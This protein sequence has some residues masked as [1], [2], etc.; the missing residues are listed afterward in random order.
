MSQIASR[1]SGAA[2][3]AFKAAC[4]A[5]LALAVVTCTDNPIGPARPGLARLRVAP[6]F[7]AFARVAPLAMDRFTITVVRPPADTLAR[8]TK[9]FSPDSSAVSVPIDIFLQSTSE[10]VDVTIELYAGS[11]LLF[12]GTQS[13]TVTQGGSTPP[14]SI[15]VAYQGP[16]SQLASLVIGPR[17]TTV[18]FG[19]TFAFGATAQDSQAAPVAQ[20][21]VAW[22]ASGGTI[23]GAGEFTAPAA[24]DTV[25]VRAVTPTGVTDSTTVIIAAAPATLVKV[26]GDA[27]SGIIGSRLALPLG[28]RVDGNDGLPV[29]GVPVT[30]AVA[31]GGGSVDSA[32]VVTDGA[33]LA[34]MGATLG[35]TVGA[36]SFTASAPGLTAVTFA[37]TGT[38]GG[39]KTWT[40][41]VSTAWTTAGNW[42]PAAVP[43]TG[44]SVLVP[45]GAPNAPT[46]S[47][48]IA[49]GALELSGN[50]ATLTIAGTFT[51]AQG[52]VLPDTSQFIQLT[53]GSLVAGSLTLDG[54]QAFVDAS[55]GGLI[56]SG[57]T[58]LAGTSA[59]VDATGP[60]SNSLG[61]VILSGTSA[62]LQQNG[63]SSGPL[64]LNGS[65]AFWNPSGAVTVNGNPAAQVT[66]TS[67]LSGGTSGAKVTL[68][69]DVI[70]GGTAAFFSPNT[71]DK[72][73]INGDLSTTGGGTLV[74]NNV[75]DTIEVNGNVSFGGGDESASLVAGI[76]NVSGNF[77]QTGPGTT[78]IGSGAHTVFLDGTGAQTLTFAAPGFGAGRFQNVI[79]ANS[80]G[81]V[82][83]TSDLYA[84]GTAGV[85]PTA[86]RTL[87]GNGST[88]FTTILSVSNFTFNNLLLDF[89]G[90][91]VV[92]FDTVSF[93]GYAPTATPLTIT[94]PGAASALAFQDVSFSV[95]PTSGFYLDATDSNPS[96]GVPLV[97]DMLNPNPLSDGGRVLE[98]GGA[99]VNWPAGVAPGTW[100]GVVDTSWNTAG[101]WSDGQVPTATTDVT[102]PSGTPFSPATSGAVR[103]VR[104]L[105]VQAGATLTMGGGGVN[106]NGSL[107]AAGL[108]TGNVAGMSLGGTGT[109]RGNVTGT[110]FLLTV[111][112]TYTL[113]GRLVATSVTV[114]GS[115]DL[116]GHTAAVGGSGA[117][118]NFNTANNGVLVMQSPLD[119][120]IMVS[121]NP[122]VGFD[123][124]STAGLLTDGVIVMA[125]AGFSTF[126]QDNTFNAASYAPSGNH[127]VVLATGTTLSLDFATPGT[128]SHFNILDV[129]AQ[130]PG[131]SLSTPIRV[132]GLFISTPASTAPAINGGNRLLTLA[133]G[134]QVTGLTLTNAPVA[135]T[136]DSP[137]TFDNVALQGFISTVTQLAVSG[138][139][140]TARVFNNL[141]FTTTPTGAGFYLVATDTDGAGSNG[142]LTVNLINPAPATPGAFSQAVNGAVIGWPPLVPVRTWTGAQN[143]DWQ[144]TTNWS[145]AGLPTASDSV[146]IP[147]VAT[148]PVLSAPVA[149]RALTVQPGAIVN[150]NSFALDVAGALSAPNA[151]SFIGGGGTLGL[152][153]TAS[154]L[155][156]TIG[157][158]VPVSITGSYALTGRTVLGNLTISGTGDIAANG[159]TLV[160]SAALNT[161][162]SGTLTMTNALDSVLVT[163]AAIFGGGSTG[164]K[165]TAGYLKVGG[166]FSQTTGITPSSFAASGSHKTELGA[167]AVRVVTFASP[168]FGT[169]TSQFNDLDITGATGGLTMNSNVA[170]LGTFTAN[171]SVGTPLLTATAGRTLEVRGG[172]VVTAL[173]VDGAPVLLDLPGGGGV[174]W[175]GVTFQNMP[176]TATQ[177]ALIHPGNASP[178]LLSN[179]VFSTTP[180]AGG[181]YL[182]ATDA[183]G[184]SPDILTLDL[185]TPTPAADGGFSQAVNGAVINW[186]FNANLH[187]WT[188]A[189]DNS[190][191]N[192]L[193]WTGGGGPGI[194]GDAVIPPGTPTTPQ[195][196]SNHQIGTLV[197]QP[198]AVLDLNGRVLTMNATVDASGQVTSG[199]AGG[200]VATF[201]G[202][203]RGNFANIS[204]EIGLGGTAAV[205]NGPVTVTGT[206]TV[207]VS[208]DVTLN[209]NTLDVSGGVFRTINGGRLLMINTLDLLLADSTDWSGG[210]QTG[211][212]TEGS[213]STR[214]FSQ[215]AAGSQDP[216]SF[217]ASGFHQVL[218]T[219]AGPSVVSFANPSTSQFDFLT[220]DGHSG[221]VTLASDVTVGGHLQ[222][223]PNAGNGPTVS[224]AGR[225]LT[226]AGANVGANPG[227]TAI[228]FDG[229]ALVLTGGTL[230]SMKD[231]T[232]TNQN[233][234]GT[235]LTV[236]NVGQAAADTFSNLVFTTTL[237]AGGF[238]LVAN[239][240]DGPTPNALTIDVVGATPLVGGAGFQATNGAVVRWPPTAPVFTWTGAVSTDWSVPGNWST[241][242]VP[243]ATDDVVI[244]VAT[245]TATV[246]GA[247]TA[248]TLL[249]NGTVDLGANN[250]QVQGDVTANGFINSTGGRIQMQAA[251]QVRGN[252]PGLEVS[253]PVT[254]AGALGLGAGPGNLI[255]TGAGASLTLNGN[256]VASPG[257]LTVQNGAVVVMTN[258]A[259]LLS[260]TGSVTFDGG[261]ET[262]LLTAGELA[263]AGNFSQ[264]ASTSP[265]SFFASGNHRTL[266]GGLGN[267][268]VSF[269]TPGGS[270]FQELDLSPMSNSAFTIG[271][272]VTVAGQLTVVPT[273]P[274]VTIN[275]LGSSTLTAGG[276]QIGSLSLATALTMDGVPL[277]LSGGAITAFDHVTFTNQSPVGTALTVN[278][279]GQGTP[280]TFANL[281]FTTSLTAGGFH[282]VATDL[283]GA[284]PNALVIDVIGATPVNGGGTFQALNGAV[285]NWPPAGGTFTWTGG[286]S[287]DWSNPAN[288]DLNA[289]PGVIDN[290]VLIPITNQPVLTTN[291]GINNLTSTAGSILDLGG[292]VLSVGGTVDLAGSIT[293]G[294]GSGVVLAGNGQLVR[295]TIATTLSVAGSYVLNGNLALTGD[296]AVAGTFDLAS[297]N[298][299]VSGVFSTI[300]SGVLVSQDV[301]AFLDV[302]GD[303]VFNGGNTAGLLTAGVLQVAG[304]FLQV[305]S[306]SP[307]SFAA[308]PPH[309]TILSADP[310][311]ITFTTPGATNGSHFG[312]LS[313]A[314]FGAVFKI[315]SDVILTGDLSGGDGFGG[316]LVG[317][318]CPLVLTLRQYFVSGPLQLDCVTL[319]VDD[320]AGINGSFSGVSFANVPT[321]VTQM[322]IRHPGVA[323][324]S[325]DFFGT[326]TFVPLTGGDTGF[327]MEAI[328]TDGAATADLTVSIPP[329][330]STNVLNGSSFTVAVPPV[331]VIW[332]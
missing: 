314:G 97:I 312:H 296:M 281:T 160:V 278:N 148:Q 30:F 175:S 52:V 21:Y 313:E 180:T 134:A 64:L 95:V 37:A 127:K 103:Q 78:F 34:S 71:G 250:C 304:N 15:P 188:G 166:S 138:T 108:I 12:R 309:Q 2:R 185:A 93:T 58:T 154:T 27:Q 169:G 4:V 29:G 216:A 294:A 85:T 5:L 189:V 223:H 68:N 87:S 212:L 265:A 317:A 239:D 113:N 150:M 112:G 35:T 246:T 31:T 308:D 84:T 14:S 120:L 133:G 70:I 202:P 129:S 57:L 267:V 243:T 23:N 170:V 322:T 163:G 325:L 114:N 164:G 219:G 201:A 328:D 260:F 315:N 174:Q 255:V 46:A 184:A 203:F 18:P 235:A 183:D 200:F 77:S 82:T 40:G 292:N 32:V 321:D 310:V 283:D 248:K 139:G 254:V 88:L 237:S 218:L 66:G 178:I 142:A 277:V 126:R 3:R 273:G 6:Q 135:I 207:F 123:G 80:A 119:S 181:F 190:W 79:I 287:S 316:S 327:Y 256:T 159:Q 236:N 226:A 326:L 96:D 329:F 56:V 53:S 231:L 17:D 286:V 74:M 301:S 228:T 43:G 285:V 72:W 171:P 101:N 261:D 102:I 305:G 7:D 298:A 177:L 318:S 24:R 232:F 143:S 165:L 244:P 222:A 323:A 280:Y 90:S 224:G 51:V 320:P 208:G 275:D 214:S 227:F 284:T 194:T 172:S 186:P 131:F 63:G 128:G 47:G 173:V 238:H 86:V 20:F 157:V 199:V 109:V 297:F 221:S 149:I 257:S 92:T 300:G 67:F 8:V 152:S 144:T 145:P 213:I 187:V 146:N 262:G 215:G 271:T 36:Q 161:T 272:D 211:L 324:G 306:N 42:S 179:L 132:N 233:P 168:G 241:G 167:A 137:V 331:T 295:G 263:F 210:N 245:P 229:V 240:L 33:G 39:L 268:G 45:A 151:T 209:S 242:A 116:A 182:S 76:L 251:G 299:T 302:G 156:G 206:G 288:W 13:L 330:G 44:D 205:L 89:N 130:A 204:I 83:A 289:V 290:V 125:N 98:N 269:A 266:I 75:A 16:G 274:G 49:I 198:G 252:L 147:A 94:H 9:T 54:F 91:T 196:S 140:A 111:N 136:G 81:G 19:A 122:V 153:G 303:A 217:A 69:G 106:V 279:V 332:P 247:C 141:T 282:L 25:T 176:T 220:L 253:A 61:G 22:S 99:T 158:A 117:G 225:T 291:V 100:T 276:A 307:Q 60:G 193:N 55:A 319:V 270:R 155:G 110:F 26:S 264:G 59:F 73:T 121:G 258:P 65:S 1:A 197:V 62:F 118:N 230:P 195:L 293:G 50:A 104:D 107:D 191:E 311:D 11:I 124:G 41:A 259:D 48:G 115:L 162:A 105:T 28:V 234:S 249:V 10:T 192:P 38:G